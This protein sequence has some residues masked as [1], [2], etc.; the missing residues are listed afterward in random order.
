MTYITRK[1]L[2]TTKFRVVS[3]KRICSEKKNS[4]KYTII[5]FGNQQKK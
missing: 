1:R 5:L 2:E 3:E 4:T